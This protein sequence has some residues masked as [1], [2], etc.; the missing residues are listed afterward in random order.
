MNRKKPTL[1]IVTQVYV[2]DPAS[3]GQHLHDAAVETAGR[4][5]QVRVV[6]AS[7]GYDDPSI[8]YP[9]HE[10]IDGVN[11]TRVP[12]S[13][14]GKRSIIVRLVAQVSF[15]LQ[16]V[17]R[18]LFVRNLGAIL[19]STSPPMASAAAM[20]IAA[21]RRVPIVYWV[22]DINPDQAVELGVVKDNSMAVKVF[23][24][25]NRAILARAHTVV[26]LDR[27][28]AARLVRKRDVVR[29]LAVF[30][31]WPH[32][33]HLEVVPHKQ[34]PFREKHDLNGKFVV[35]YSGNHSPANPISTIIEAAERLQNRGDIVFVFV[36]G[37]ASKREV[38]AAVERGARNIIDLPYQP[39]SEI[40][41]SLSA[42][43]L[44]VVSVGV[45][46]VG[47]VHPCK[48]YG[49]MA[50]ARPILLVGPK[51]S[52]VSDLLD[53]SDIGRHANLGHVDDAVA[54]ILELADMLS[55]TRIQMG[56]R[57]HELVQNG[58]SKRV[59]CAR[60]GNV[61]ERALLRQPEPTWAQFPDYARQDQPA[62][63]ADP[64]AEKKAA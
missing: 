41:F 25:L 64:P 28:M 18:G 59:L 63:Q 37:G 62:V 23:N 53:R 5:Y 43:D 54:A 55:V 48:V 35:M 40:K 45:S 60:F 47:V 61:L 10:E 2:P 52:H 19:V 46:S 8:R 22:M 24:A 3:V 29:K 26:T 57:G 9:R 58:L 44:H 15:L 30:P 32:D 27:F 49:A 6:A 14:F 31:P 56:Q 42:A 38:A 4:E 20:I 16:A 7:R 33:D 12:F 21:I 51:P 36:G 11:V 39:F 17:V 1:L 50:V 13:S 34:N